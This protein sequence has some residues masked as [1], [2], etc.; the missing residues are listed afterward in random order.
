M[1]LKVVSGQWEVSDYY[2]CRIAQGLLKNYRNCP[3]IVKTHFTGPSSQFLKEPTT[4]GA[5]EG[6][7]AFDVLG[8]ETFLVRERPRARM[9]VDK[10]ASPH[11]ENPSII[12]GCDD[13]HD[14]DIRQKELVPFNCASTRYITVQRGTLM[15]RSHITPLSLLQSTN[16]P[17]S[18]IETEL[19]QRHLGVV[20][21]IRMTSI[22]FLSKMVE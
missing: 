22:P 3:K 17:A 4:S 8:C 2:H 7:T 16:E 21:L 14:S 20:A 18:F 1:T 15:E 19:A 10:L 6:C 12:R 5:L 11:R 13:V 9:I